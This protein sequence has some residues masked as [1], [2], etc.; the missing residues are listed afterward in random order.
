MTDPRIT[1]AQDAFRE[2]KRDLSKALDIVR[3]EQQDKTDA[4][5][6]AEFKAFNKN[7]P[8]SADERIVFLRYVRSAARKWGAVYFVLMLD[9]LEGNEKGPND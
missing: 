3:A 7:N 6:L 4:D 1:Q 8:L 2:A 9:I 5:S